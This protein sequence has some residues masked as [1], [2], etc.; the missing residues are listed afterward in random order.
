L[1]GLYLATIVFLRISNQLSADGCTG[2]RGR[3]C[4]CELEIKHFS[5]AHFGRLVKL[6]LRFKQVSAL[7]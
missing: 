7:V 3:S 6:E 5:N 4:A 2:V 1:C